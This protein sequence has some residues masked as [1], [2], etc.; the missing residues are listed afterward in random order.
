MDMAECANHSGGFEGAAAKFWP[1]VRLQPSFP[2]Q[3]REGPHEPK[4]A[5]TE[6]QHPEVLAKA[7]DAS[8]R[9]RLQTQQQISRTRERAAHLSLLWVRRIVQAERPA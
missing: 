2:H 4:A 1:G 6:S 3:C 8:S 7:A 5:A 9:P